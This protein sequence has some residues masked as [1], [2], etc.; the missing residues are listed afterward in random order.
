VAKGYFKL[1]AYKDEYEVARLYTDGTFA[2]QLAEQFTGKV[3]LEVNLAP[4][5][6]ARRDAE[7]HLMKR[8]YGPWM[9][10]AFRLLAK[11]KFL[12]G[13]ALDPFGW[14][15]ERRGERRLVVD[16]EALVAQI[17]AGLT[18]ANLAAAIELASLPEKIRGFGHVKARNLEAAKQCE[19]ELLARFR[20]VE[21]A[22]R[23]EKAVAA[24]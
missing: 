5:L 17:L 9:L 1:L 8:A 6:L 20:R 11:L 22:A 12:R 3:R 21:P 15:T 10:T 13:S 24:Q 18:P 23:P 19:A 2:R 4:P 16:Y 7:G 14:S